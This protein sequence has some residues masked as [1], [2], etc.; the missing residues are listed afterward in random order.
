MNVIVL[1]NDTF[2][3]DHVGCYGNTWIQT[4][5]L[6][7]FAQRSAST[8]WPLIQPCQIDGIY[9]AG[10]LGS[11]AWVAAVEPWRCH[12]GTGYVPSWYAYPDDLGYA[13]AGKQ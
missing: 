13:D 10:D 2:R 6:D 5:N 1:V 8:T 11:H 3:R 4:P 9:Q 7:R 12:L